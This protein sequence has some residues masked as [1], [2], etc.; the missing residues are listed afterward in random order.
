MVKILTRLNVTRLLKFKRK[1][2]STK[3]RYISIRQRSTGLFYFG[4][5]GFS[6][7]YFKDLRDLR[8]I[9]DKVLIKYV[10]FE[11]FEYVSFVS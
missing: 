5:L 9:N 6:T 3:C 10:S 11:S 7:S 2:I 4:L 1:Q 8:K